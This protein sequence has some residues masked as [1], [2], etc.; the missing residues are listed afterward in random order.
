MIDNMVCIAVALLS[1]SAAFLAGALFSAYVL[2]SHAEE[3]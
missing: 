3:E 1:A 2:Q